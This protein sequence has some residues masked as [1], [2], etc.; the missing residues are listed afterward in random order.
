MVATTAKAAIL[1]KGAITIKAV[2]M[3]GPV[4]WSTRPDG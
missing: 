2:I 4:S 1:T 3:P